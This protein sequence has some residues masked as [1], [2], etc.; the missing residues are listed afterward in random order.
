MRALRSVPRVPSY[1]VPV[2][3]SELQM[4]C[5]IVRYAD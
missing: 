5:R 1:R 3:L 2:E 4:R